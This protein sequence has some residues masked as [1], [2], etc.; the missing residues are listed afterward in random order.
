[1]ADREIVR[2]YG[3]DGEE[4]CQIQGFAALCID[5]AEREWFYYELQKR[6]KEELAKLK[7]KIAAE[8]PT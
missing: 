7:A 5:D 8:E 4:W 6:A 1:M 3:L 2:D